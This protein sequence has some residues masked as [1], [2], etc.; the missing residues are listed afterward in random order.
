MQAQ[1]F[2]IFTDLLIVLHESNLPAVIGPKLDMLYS[3]LQE[4]K[5]A[6]KLAALSVALNF[7]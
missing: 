3:R 2:Q 4:K 7:F 5:T 1:C 6:V